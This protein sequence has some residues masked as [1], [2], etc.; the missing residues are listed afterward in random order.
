MGIL[1]DPWGSLEV[2]G[3][4]GYPW[5]FLGGLYGSLRVFRAGVFG[6]VGFLGGLLGFWGGLW[7][8]LRVFGDLLR[9]DLLKIFFLCKIRLSGF[10]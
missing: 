9:L 1:G 2:L 5:K 8:S 3:C 6:S 4:H 10:S 7:G